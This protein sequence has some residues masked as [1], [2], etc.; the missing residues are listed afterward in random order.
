MKRIAAGLIALV[1]ASCATTPEV[2]SA[3]RDIH[4]F[5]IAIRDGDRAVFEN[6]VDREALKVQLRSR[7]LAEAMRQGRGG[8]QVNALAALLGSS[9]MGVATDVLIQPEVFRAIAESRGY[10][11]DMGMPS[12]M[13]IAR[14]V[15]PLGG[16]AACVVFDSDG[17]CVLNFK[18]SGGNWR[19]IGFEGDLSMLR[20]G[21]S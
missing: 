5:L 13:L 17:P 1:L 18:N 7:V 10:R 19:L 15:R 4:R 21:R 20:T 16:D 11:P 6:H 12:P 14:A 2:D 3:S 9:M 8:D